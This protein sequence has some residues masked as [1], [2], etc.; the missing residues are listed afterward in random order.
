MKT[1]PLELPQM[2][3]AERDSIVPDGPA[4]IW[5]TDTA[6]S[7]MYVLGS[8]WSPVDP[9]VVVPTEGDYPSHYLN[10]RAV[11][12]GT[13]WTNTTEWSDIT[14]ARILYTNTAVDGISLTDTA[15][16]RLRYRVTETGI[17]RY[18]FQ[19]RI[20]VSTPNVVGLRLQRT[21]GV[22]VTYPLSSY[23]EVFGTTPPICILSGLLE[24]ESEDRLEVQYY[25]GSGIQS[26][27][28]QT[29]DGELVH[30]GSAHLYRIR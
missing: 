28:A 22:D 23:S 5:N 3:T 9:P 8:G 16:Q 15:T 29:L 2:T 30:N 13:F 6:A 17:F 4:M 24:L 12:T 26:T 18:F 7:E 1:G 10:Q 20:N 25:V 21:S 14:N 19:V 27:N 11:D